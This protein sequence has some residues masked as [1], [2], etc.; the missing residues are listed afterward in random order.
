MSLASMRNELVH[1]VYKHRPARVTPATVLA[2]FANH[3]NLQ[4]KAAFIKLFEDMTEKVGDSYVC[5]CGLYAVDFVYH[6]VTD[7]LKDF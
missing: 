5:N 1:F 4:N 3:L 2:Y 6:Y 7:T